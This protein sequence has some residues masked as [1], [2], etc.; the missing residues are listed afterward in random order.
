MSEAARHLAD[1]DALDERGRTA[2]AA[3]EVFALAGAEDEAQTQFA[4]ALDLLER[5][6]NLAFAD[7]LRSAVAALS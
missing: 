1:T 3:S 6:G 7:Q 2:A 4:L 5:K